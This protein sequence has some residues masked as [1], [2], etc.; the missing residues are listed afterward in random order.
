MVYFD[1][2]KKFF[3]FFI[4]CILVKSELLMYFGVFVKLNL[5]LFLVK[6]VMDSF[7]K[8]IICNKFWKGVVIVIYLLIYLEKI[9]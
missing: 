6:V 7:F 3:K 9:C 8:E 2:K 1:T 4:N 5:M